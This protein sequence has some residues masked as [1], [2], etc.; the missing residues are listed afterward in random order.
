MR[1]DFSGTVLSISFLLFH[2]TH[3]PPKN[4]THTLRNLNY[5]I[6]ETKAVLK[7]SSHIHSLSDLPAPTRLPLRDENLVPKTVCRTT[8][9][10]VYTTIIIFYNIFLTR[11]IGSHQSRHYYLILNLRPALKCEVS[12]Q[13]SHNK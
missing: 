7:H 2:A 8:T 13:G 5:H 10:Y 3:H 9:V 6:T 4:T 1:F 12:G 11:V